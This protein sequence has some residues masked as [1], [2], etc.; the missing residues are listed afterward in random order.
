MV[1]ARVHDVSRALFQSNILTILNAMPQVSGG[2]SQRSI[3]VCTW[4]LVTVNIFTV[5]L[6]SV[7]LADILGAI[8]PF[9]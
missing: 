9:N 6:K 5:P 2:D 8:V 1:S 4:H 7:H 3:V